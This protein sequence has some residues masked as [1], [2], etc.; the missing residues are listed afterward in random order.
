MTLKKIDNFAEIWNSSASPTEAAERLGIT[1]NQAYYHASRLRREGREIKRFKN[2]LSVADDEFITSYN[3]HSRSVASLAAEWGV[4]AVIIARRASELKAAGRGIIIR[5]G[6]PSSGSTDRRRTDGGPYNHRYVAYLN[7]EQ[8][9]RLERLLN[10][11]TFSNWVT[12]QLK[13]EL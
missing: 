3:D 5:M 7:A 1:T 2:S 10:G 12:Q 4:S 6:R 8:A 11:Q 13:E 9:E